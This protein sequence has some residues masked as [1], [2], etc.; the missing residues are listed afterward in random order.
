L[1]KVEE[2]LLRFSME[3]KSLFSCWASNDEED[4]QNHINDSGNWRDR[5]KKRRDRGYETFGDANII[6]EGYTDRRDDQYDDRHSD[7][8]DNR[9]DN[10]RSGSKGIR[11][12]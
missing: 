10:N 9:R 4:D 6:A 11:G 12:N 5:R 1:V 7:R 8:R 3:K 2:G